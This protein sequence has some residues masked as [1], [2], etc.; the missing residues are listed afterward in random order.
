MSDPRLLIGGE[1]RLAS[2]GT[3]IAA[4][5]PS[6]GERFAVIPREARARRQ[7]AAAC[8]L[9][10]GGTKRSGFGREKGFEALYGFSTVKTVA[11][12]HG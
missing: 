8:V 10:F 1:W 12:H 11:I 4:I 6:D 5:D 2:D 7:V 3:A 9:L